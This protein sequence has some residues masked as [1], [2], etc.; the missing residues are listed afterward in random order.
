MRLGVLLTYDISIEEWKRI[1]VLQKEINYYKKLFYNHKIKTTLIS[2]GFKK[3][4]KILKKYH[5]LEVL[6]IY[7]HIHFFKN[8][9]LRLLISF[10]IFFF[11]KKKLT[12]ID[13]IKTNQF[14]GS[15][16]LLVAKFFFKKKFIIRCGYEFN[17]NLESENGKL[18]LKIFSK[19]FSFIIYHLSQKIIVTSKEIKKYISKNFSIKNEKI[20]VVPNSIDL[21]IFKNIKKKKFKNKILYVGRNS[22]EKNLSSIFQSLKNKNIQID[23]IGDGF[24][25]KQIR[26]WKKKYKIK[27][28]Y[29][30]RKENFKLP[31]YFN[32]YKVLVLP[33]FYEGN[34]KVIL[35]AMA[36]GCVVCGSD[37]DAIRS[38]IKDKYNG[39]ILKKSKKE[40]YRQIK[41]NLEIKNSFITQ[42]AIKT[43]HKKYNLKTNLI[44]E[45]NIISKIYEKNNYTT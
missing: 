20:T 34:P 30:G 16:S 2:F 25:K 45:W 33:S 12:D 19:V 10:F 41:K 43:I 21:N 1:G 7:E 39:I 38:I 8:K 44:L 22:P 13:V 28:D 18:F 14:W 35:E 40:I 17:K 37:I 15:W 9:F 27:V 36:C 5:F 29:L 24:S 4:I 11:L 3:D 26:N 23:I 32:S 31:Y 42:N 6:P